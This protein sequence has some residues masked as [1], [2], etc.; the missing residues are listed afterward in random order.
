MTD[1]QADEE[2]RAVLENELVLLAPDASREELETLL[3]PDFGELIST[4]PRRSRPIP[5]TD[6]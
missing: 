2:M 6:G 1:T 5:G 3:H 4:R